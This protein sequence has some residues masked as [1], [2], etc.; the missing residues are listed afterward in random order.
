MLSIRVAAV[1]LFGAFSVWAQTQEINR[2]R[3]APE[4]TTVI[5]ARLG[6]SE[7]N[8]SPLTL[9]LD[10]TPEL[11]EFTLAENSVPSPVAASSQP[12]TSPSKAVSISSGFSTRHKIHKYAS[13]AT[14]PL[15]AAEGV[16]GQKLLDS[17]GNVSGSL[18]S[19]HSA[20]AGGN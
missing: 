5:L 1:I 20:L 11:P 17:T 7:T 8:P 19:T 3:E 16:F 12:S 2:E 15:L 4:T 14:L 13:Y 6:G 10:R 18:R 9:K